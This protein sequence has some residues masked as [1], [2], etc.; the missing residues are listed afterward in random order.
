MQEEK[1]QKEKQ[2]WE[3]E[4]QW[5]GLIDLTYIIY[6]SNLVCADQLFCFL[7]SGGHLISRFA[8]KGLTFRLTPK[9]PLYGQ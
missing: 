8:A 3:K 5:Y 1:L 7:L 6:F 2:K 4:K 9:G